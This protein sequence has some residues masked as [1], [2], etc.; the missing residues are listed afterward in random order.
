MKNVV[1]W[2]VTPCGSCK[3][4]RYAVCGS[5]ILFTLKMEV[6][7]S[8]ESTILKRPIRRHT[9]EDGFFVMLFIYARRIK[10]Y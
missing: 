5:P 3:K 6:T 2:N 8:S 7:R 4:G 10:H 1:F 9:S